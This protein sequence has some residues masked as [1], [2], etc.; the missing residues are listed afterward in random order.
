MALWLCCRT[1]IRQRRVQTRYLQR[2]SQPTISLK[3]SALLVA[4]QHRLLGRPILGKRLRP[5]VVELDASGPGG[6]LKVQH[7]RGQQ[8]RRD[9][10]V[11]ALALREEGRR[12]QVAADTGQLDLK[13][14]DGIRVIVVPGSG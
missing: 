8:G 9:S 10:S 2:E 4:F 1:S 12:R 3:L 13:R 6:L 5:E 7:L 14:A 11:L